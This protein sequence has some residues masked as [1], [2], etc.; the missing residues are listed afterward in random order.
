MASIYFTWET[1]YWARL[2]ILRV[3][4]C[5]RKIPPM[6]TPGLWG[7]SP[8]VDWYTIGFGKP[9]SFL[10]NA[11][12]H[13][14]CSGVEIGNLLLQSGLKRLE[15]SHPVSSNFASIF[16]YRRLKI[17]YFVFCVILDQFYDNYV[18]YVNTQIIHSFF[19]FGK[20]KI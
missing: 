2:C 10:Q 8:Y 11:P 5:S 16:H 17:V 9:A 1:K 14:E 20:S 7:K 19:I 15:R 4:I 18:P 6:G 12:S 3:L 13:G